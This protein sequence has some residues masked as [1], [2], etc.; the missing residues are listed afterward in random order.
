M[1]IYGLQPSH[2]TLKRGS[3]EHPLGS[4]LV[5][6]PLRGRDRDF[7]DGKHFNHLTKSS[8]MTKMGKHTD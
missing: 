4:G 5:V 6:I 7:R 8:R 2:I 1:A 3:K